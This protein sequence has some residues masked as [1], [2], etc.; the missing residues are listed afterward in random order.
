MKR[1]LLVALVAPVLAACGT[2]F[3]QEALSVSVQNADGGEFRQGHVHTVT[4]T[5][6][7]T[8]NWPLLLRD[9]EPVTNEDETWFAFQ[10]KYYGSA[11]TASETHV[12]YNPNAQQATAAIFNEGFL[13]PGQSLTFKKSHRI[14]TAIEEV[15]VHY[16]VID[17]PRG[18]SDVTT[19]LCMSAGAAN[20][21]VT[22]TVEQLEAF[23]AGSYPSGPTRLR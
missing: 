3:R 2:V 23:G 13:M 4:Y 20:T 22:P 5:V 1:A 16:T 19:R 15:K 17:T 12:T 11:N 18:L 21:Y 8:S 6:T 10:R 14:V 7:N 9:I